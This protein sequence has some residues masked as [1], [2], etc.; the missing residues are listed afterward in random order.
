MAKMDL[1]KTFRFGAISAVA[2]AILS[3]LVGLFIQPV[4]KIQFAMIDTQLTAKVGIPSM[5]LGTK[6]V[7]AIASR[8]GLPTGNI[9]VNILV[10]IAGGGLAVMLGSFAY[11]IVHEKN[12]LTGKPFLVP[13]GQVGRIALVLF[14]SGLFGG[15]ILGTITGLPALGTAITL[16][17]SALV[18]A[19]ILMIILNI[20]AI[21]ETTF[22]KDSMITL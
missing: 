7:T 1:V 20:K 3:W 17:F 18:T 21:K 22:V 4:A 2:L 5:G 13:R 19:W 16:A 6:L 9:L 8:I 11:K 12:V 14:H 15:L 10:I